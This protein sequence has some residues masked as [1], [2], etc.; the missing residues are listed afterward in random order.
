MHMVSFLQKNFM[1]DSVDVNLT[2]GK[3]TVVEFLTQL[4]DTKE[5]ESIFLAA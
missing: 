5:K 4:W 1:A 3:V 2:I